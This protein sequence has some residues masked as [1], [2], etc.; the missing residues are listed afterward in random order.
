MVTILDPGNPIAPAHA[1]H[2]SGLGGMTG[3]ADAE[4]SMTL[5][6]KIFTHP[7]HF[8]GGT[9]EAMDEQAANPVTRK[10]EG[11]SSGNNQSRHETS[12]G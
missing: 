7:E 1:E 11:F 9:G 2:V 6:G 12:L 5:G 8:F 4:D 10:E 3:K